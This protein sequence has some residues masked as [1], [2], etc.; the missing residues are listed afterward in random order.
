MPQRSPEWFAIRA[1]IPT[2]SDAGKLITSTGKKSTQQADY[3]YQLAAD[4]YAGKPLDR[5][6]GNASTERGRELEGEA[7]K[8]YREDTGAWIETV[9]FCTD[10]DG[11]YG[12]S[13]DG[14][15]DDG[16]VEIKCLGAKNHVKALVYHNK[17]KCAPPD[18]IPQVHMQMLVC[19]RGWC[20][21]FYYH[22][23]LPNLIVRQY[24]VDT[25]QRALIEQ[26]EICIEARDN[27]LNIIKKEE[28]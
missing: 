16:M 3:A 18:Y 19:N 23:D 28:R 13:P 14:L 6:E 7:L 4:L 8:A 9:G 10:D 12:C 21:L 22:P 1:G 20:D 17:T 5:W 24:K 26:L 11:Y 2:A 25:L 15:T 27:F